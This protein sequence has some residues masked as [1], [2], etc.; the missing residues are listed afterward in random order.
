M[1]VY[2][3]PYVSPAPKYH[4]G[5]DTSRAPMR[6]TVQK[7]RC[8]YRRLDDTLR[9]APFRNPLKGNTGT[10]VSSPRRYLIAHRSQEQTLHRAES[11]QVSSRRQYPPMCPN[12]GAVRMR[13]TVHGYRRL[14]D[15]SS[16]ITHTETK[17][18]I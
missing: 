12:I 8:T 15:M 5:N 2:G 3:L 14:D 6:T 16:P 10:V 18:L 9:S 7:E 13:K 4:Q 1:K 11:G 17:N